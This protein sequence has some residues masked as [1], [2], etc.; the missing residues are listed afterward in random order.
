[1]HDDARQSL[2]HEAAWYGRIRWRPAPFAFDTQLL[3]D[4]GT[5]L[6][7]ETHA[8]TQVLPE[9][10]CPVQ[11]PWYGSEPL[12]SLEPPEPL[13]SLEPLEPLAPLEPLES[14]GPPP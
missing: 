4:D 10:Q 9:W 3:G 13:E 12:E 2:L 1:M 14:L 11:Q 5:Q 6:L 8:E 7:G